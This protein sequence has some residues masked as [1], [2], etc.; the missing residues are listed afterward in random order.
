MG[1]EGLQDRVGK[2]M[3]VPGE[4]GDSGISTNYDET[5]EP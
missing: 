4:K 2:L 3:G 1:E 5:K